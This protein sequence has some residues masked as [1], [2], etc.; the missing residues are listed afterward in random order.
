LRELAFGVAKMTETPLAGFKN[1]VSACYDRIAMNLV[2]AVFNRMG[3]PRDLSVFNNRH[4]FEW[5]A[6]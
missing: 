6:V 3:V 5:H 4:F 1:D 2:S